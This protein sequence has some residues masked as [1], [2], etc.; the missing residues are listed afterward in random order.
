MTAAPDAVDRT[1]LARRGG[2]NLVGAVGSAGLNFGLTV[3]VTRSLAVEEAGTFFAVTSLLLLLVGL[4]RLGSGT[5]LVYWISRLR[6]LGRDDLVGACLRHALTPVVAVSLVLAGAL[7]LGA[8]QVAGLLVGEGSQRDAATGAVRAV[9]LL[10]PFAAV[11]EGVLGASRGYHDMR[12]TVGVEK[13]LRPAL[14]LALVAAV[15][16]VGLAAVSLAWAAPYLPA[17]LLGSGWLVRLRRR[18]RRSPP[19]E[20]SLAELARPV[21]ERRRRRREEARPV[22]EFSLRRAYWSFTAPRAL[23]GLVQVVLQR[24]DVLLVT[25]LL[26]AGSAAVYVAAS[27]LLVLGAFGIQAV[28]MAVQP[29]LAAHFAR[30]ELDAA[31]TL[32]RL[33]TTWLVLLTWPLYLVGVVHPA[34]VLS[35]FGPEYAAG[36]DVLVVLACATLLSTAC[37]VVDAMLTM[38]GRTALILVNVAASLVVNVSLNLLLIPTFGIIGAA[39]AWAGAIAVNNLLPLA[40]VRWSLGLHPFGRQGAEAIAVTVGSWLLPG[41]LW[42][43][44]LGAGA[45]ALAA[46]VVVGAVVQC[47]LM[48]WRRDALALAELVPVRRRR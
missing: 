43:Q 28:T 34:T 7:L 13:L 27:R 35:I 48:W 2:L 37:G 5:G 16:S 46:T 1:G 39:W 47:A 19:V 18:A 26:D 25:V 15:A 11:L 31:R 29:Q 33:S 40:Q 20:G 42:V 8:D 9:A 3:V 44:L 30:R 17:L 10:L 6:A 36:R 12:P 23:S 4:A 38:A 41:V 32:Y 24:L 22:R 21:G 45:P 14:Q